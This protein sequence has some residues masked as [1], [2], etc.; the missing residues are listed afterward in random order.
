MKLQ[1]RL[2]G[3]EVAAVEISRDQPQTTTTNAPSRG[4]GGG[5]THNFEMSYGDPEHVAFGFR[6]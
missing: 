1:L 6:S 2:F 4:A 3:R 5:S